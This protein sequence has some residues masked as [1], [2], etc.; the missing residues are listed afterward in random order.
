MSLIA[1]VRGVLA[2]PDA[3][4]SVLHALNAALALPFAFAQ[5][6]VFIRVLGPEAY[7]AVVLISLYGIYLSPIDNAVARAAFAT[8]RADHVGG[9]QGPARDLVGFVYP[10]DLGLRLVLVTGLSIAIWRW[11]D[12]GLDPLAGILFLLFALLNNLWS[13]QLQSVGWALDRALAFE[14]G[15]VLRNIAQLALLGHLLWSGDFLLYLVLANLVWLLAVGQLVWSLRRDTGLFR[16]VQRPA[17]ATSL[18]AFLRMIGVAVLASLAE[19]ALLAGPYLVVVAGFG[20]GPALVAFDTAQKLVRAVL[21]VAKM[22]S[23]SLLPQQSRAFFSGD[24]AALRRITLLIAGCSLVPAAGLSAVLLVSGTWIFDVLLGGHDLVPVAALAPI[25]LLGWLAAAYHIGN[26]LLSYTGRFAPVAAAGVV[27]A[28]GLAA[29]LAA[30]RW[31]GL[32]VP[33]FFWAYAATFAATAGL[34]ATVAA[35]HAARIQAAEAG[36]P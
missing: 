31:A 30:V 11:S 8:L 22:A 2:R 19:L 28:L 29:T 26:S 17:R 35:R 1:R 13:Y 25:A 12:S 36:A 15:Q 21:S 10:L 14:K 20:T 23:E 33:G 5:T 3:R 27:T 16:R 4:F 6:F 7:A 9:G 34:V 32:D 18:T 24:R